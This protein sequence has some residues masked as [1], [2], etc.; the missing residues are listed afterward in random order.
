[1]MGLQCMHFGSNYKTDGSFLLVCRQSVNY[2]ESQINK[3]TN[4]MSEKM[5]RCSQSP[6]CRYR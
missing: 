2:D 4:L 5:M 6:W 1:M 3:Q